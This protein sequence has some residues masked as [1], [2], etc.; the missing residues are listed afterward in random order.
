M[1]KDK[2]LT[3]IIDKMSDNG[4][5]NLKTMKNN[6]FFIDRLN[7]KDNLLNM[8][9]ETDCD[10]EKIIRFLRGAYFLE[11]IPDNIY[12][13]NG[14]S[15]LHVSALT[16]KS[17][18]FID[19][20]LTFAIVKSTVHEE[21]EE[22]KINKYE[23]LTH[24]NNDNKTF[25][26]ILLENDDIF[27]HELLDYFL[28]LIHKI[29]N[30]SIDYIIDYYEQITNKVIDSGMINNKFLD[31]DFF[32]ELKKLCK[33]NI[34]SSK[35]FCERTKEERIKLLNSLFGDINY[36][37]ESGNLLW[38]CVFCHNGIYTE[39]LVN[40]LEC[41]VN[42]NFKKDEKTIIH[43]I[44]YDV[45]SSGDVIDLLNICIKYGYDVNQKPSIIQEC[46]NKW[47]TSPKTLEVYKFLCE[48]GFNS[49]ISDIDVAYILNHPSKSA[50]DNV[51]DKIIDMYWNNCI[52]ECFSNSFKENAMQLEENFF[53]KFYNV[54]NDFNLFKE[55]IR[56]FLNID[57]KT[58]LQLIVESVIEIR[59]ENVSNSKDYVTAN[60]IFDGIKYLVIKKQNDFLNNVDKVKQK[61]NK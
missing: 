55:Q 49:S 3:N 26:D 60:D 5:Y 13:E 21:W 53:D 48:N 1:Q 50:D 45:T 25:M 7:R 14:N 16:G 38:N 4:R 61:N 59:K 12:D 11:S 51:T 28:S 32:E 37:D 15:F 44:I 17:F 20:V 22:V 56:G 41:G 42:P 43:E 19:Q 27:Q 9:I 18:H 2:K 31:Y 57:E 34:L 36:S 35:R 47:G 29:S 24:K 54:I 30:I 33:K 8:A 58:I 23:L 46:L 39:S 52:Y 40:F 6:I 10:E